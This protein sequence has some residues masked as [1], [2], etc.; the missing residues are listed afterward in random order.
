TVVVAVQALFFAD[1]GLTALGYNI[2]NMAIV[3][4][5]GGYALFRIFKRILPNGRG[6]SV[7]ATALAAWGSVVLSAAAFSIQ[8]LFGATAPIPFTRVFAAMVGVHVL[9]GI[10][11]AV[12]SAQRSEER[13]VGKECIS[14]GWARA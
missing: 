3:P 9:I 13:R 10:G 4:A 2:L 8:W 1:G 11:E 6:G 5:Y 14:R 12:I 7:G